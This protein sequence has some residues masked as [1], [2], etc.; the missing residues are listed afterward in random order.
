ML[1]STEAICRKLWDQLWMFWIPDFWVPRHSELSQKISG[2][3]QCSPLWILLRCPGNSVGLGYNGAT[4]HPALTWP[5]CRCPRWLCKTAIPVTFDSAFAASYIDWIIPFAFSHFCIIARL[6]NIDSTLRQITSVQEP[7]ISWMWST[8]AHH[9]RIMRSKTGND[10]RFS[11]SGRRM[12]G[13]DWWIDSW[14]SCVMTSNAVNRFSLRFSIFPSFFFDF[15]WL[16]G[17]ERLESP[18]SCLSPWG[19]YW[20]AIQRALVSV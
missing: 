6:W 10:I 9:V 16:C 14:E 1:S 15:R 2:W 7:V 8:H 11:D 4:R 19:D 5:T 20:A 18:Q 13:C 3:C 12:P 17:I